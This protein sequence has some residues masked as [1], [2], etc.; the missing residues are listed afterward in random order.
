MIFNSDMAINQ[1]SA[2]E[3]GAFNNLPKIQF[4]YDHSAFFIHLSHLRDLSYNRI[5][6]IQPEVFAAV[7]TLLGLYAVLIYNKFVILP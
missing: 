6:F 7:T 4:L 5:T 3:L 2:I 1:I